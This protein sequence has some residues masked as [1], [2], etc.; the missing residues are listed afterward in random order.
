MAS[1]SEGE[2]RSHWCPLCGGSSH[3]ATGCY[4]SEG[5]VVCWRCTLELCR[6]LE[7]WTREKGA[8]SGL[9]FYEHAGKRAAP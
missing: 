2:C 6:W 9:L 1:G 8:R 7:R 4:Y 5:F 3:P